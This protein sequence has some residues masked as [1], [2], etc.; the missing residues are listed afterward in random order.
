MNNKLKFLYILCHLTIMPAYF[1][2]SINW[3]LVSICA[4]LFLQLIGV[5]IG[6]HRYFSHNSFSTGKHK[7]LFLLLVS[8]IT[9]MGSPISWA[10][11]HRLH[12][13]YADTDKDP[14]SPSQ[15]GVFY[16]LFGLYNTELKIPNFFIKNFFKSSLL[17]FAHKNYFKIL[18]IWVGGLFVFGGVNAVIFI[19]CLPVVL[20]YWATAIGIVLNHKWGY[21]NFE[22]KDKS[23][24]SW[25]LSLYTLG[26]GW[27]NNHHKFPDKYNNRYNWWEWDLCALLIKVFFITESIKDKSS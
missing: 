23:V 17:V 21:R 6:L 14:H 15:K 27:H 22:T 26:G 2:G 1:L 12:H 19:F 16:I 5:E 11:I 20:V 8:V 4:Y 13:K 9:A 24:N 3:F 10:G 7:E 25:V 18:F